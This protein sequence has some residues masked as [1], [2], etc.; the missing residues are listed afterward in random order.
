MLGVGDMDKINTVIIITV[1][2]RVLQ[3]LQ[4]DSKSHPKKRN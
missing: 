2:L 1:L 4:K 3:Y